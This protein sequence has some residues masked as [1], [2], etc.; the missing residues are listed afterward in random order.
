MDVQTSSTDIRASRGQ[1]PWAS[2]SKRSLLAVAAFSA[3]ALAWLWL[4]IVAISNF[5]FRYPAFDQYRAYA[6]YLSL[7]FP[8]NAVQIDNGHR[9]IIPTLVRLAEIR[10][11]DANQR[12]QIVV[13]CA[14]ALMTL[15]LICTTILRDHTM[16]PIRRAACCL[17]AT[18][19]LFWLGNARMLMHGNEAMQVYGVMVFVT[20]AIFTMG[21]AHATGEW[22]WAL[23]CAACCTLATFSFGNGIASFAAVF[24]TALVLRTRPANVAFPILLFAGVMVVYLFAL[25]GGGEAR[26]S[27]LFDSGSIAG[28]L[29]RWLSAPWIHAWLGYADPPLEPT[30]SAAVR[31]SGTLGALLVS[32]ARGV[33]LAFGSD[34][35][36]RES[37]LLGGIGLFGWIAIAAHACRNRA[38]LHGA[39]IAAIGLATFALVTGALVCIARVRVFAQTPLDAYADRYLPWSCLFWFG[40]AL[41]I[42][43][44][45]PKRRRFRQ[46]LFPLVAMSAALVFAPSNNALAIWSA[47]V[48]QH[49]QQSAVAAQ[50]GIWDAERFPDGADARRA[51][52]LETLGR[53]KSA[54]LS[55]FAEPAFALVQANAPRPSF[56]SGTFAGAA[57]KVVR[58]FHDTLGQRE[59]AAFDGAVPLTSNV[60]DASVLAVVDAAGRL[61]GLAKFSFIGPA[62][63]DLRW[64][65]AHLRGFD[66][67]VL[68]PQPGEQLQIEILDSETMAALGSVPLRVPDAQPPSP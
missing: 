48:H 37:A 5:A 45:N 1:P 16:T 14:A 67:Y 10:W 27:L 54:H 49:I 66:G 30:L 36:A 50:L 18:M 15:L 55:M 42:G 39:R 20:L 26:G 12:L 28:A 24:V 56:A 3:L 60:S 23:L 65:F 52:V 2:R 7:P 17:L 63:K 40:L 62:A 11:F 59:V 47:I 61:R 8:A 9:P 22:M 68:D 4:S 43:A 51:I 19:A 64:S 34:W 44:G 21:R 57:A 6:N 35:L 13:G 25:P 58:E 29:C 38:T 53:L 41:Y 31:G 33:S 46:A 32:S